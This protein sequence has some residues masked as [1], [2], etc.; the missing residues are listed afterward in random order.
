MVLIGFILMGFGVCVVV[1]GG[2][3]LGSLCCF[4]DNSLGSGLGGGWQ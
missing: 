1:T 2:Y 3:F 4:Y